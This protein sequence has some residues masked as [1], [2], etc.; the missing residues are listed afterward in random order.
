VV[1]RTV[2]G[3]GSVLDSCDFYNEKLSSIEGEECLNRPNKCQFLK[4]SLL[5]GVSQLIP[6]TVDT[7][8]NL[9]QFRRICYPDLTQYSEIVINDIDI[10]IV[11]I[12]WKS[13]A[14]FSVSH[15]NCVWESTVLELLSSTSGFSGVK[16]ARESAT[17]E[18]YFL[19]VS[20]KLELCARSARKF[21]F[22]DYIY[23][24]SWP[25]HKLRLCHYY[26]Y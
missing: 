9:L 3:T 10:E 26:M 19:P 7:I 13:E 17:A 20:I 15:R 18:S 21:H 1:V 12:I 8:L 5:P 24:F 2:F 23:D 22:C 16:P 11:I 25:L 4:P 14:Q 6:S